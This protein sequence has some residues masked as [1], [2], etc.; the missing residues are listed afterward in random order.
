LRH[1]RGS[2]C[3]LRGAKRLSPTSTAAFLNGRCVDLEDA[4][5]NIAVG[6]SDIH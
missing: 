5:D 1:S 2:D 4:A 3:D 6:Q